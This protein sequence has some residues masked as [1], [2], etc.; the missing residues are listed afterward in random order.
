LPLITDIA[1]HR[2]IEP[3][4][5]ALAP[6]Q[7]RLA[8][9]ELAPLQ[10]YTDMGYCNAATIVDS[11]ERGIDLRGRVAH[12]GAKA[13]GFRLEDFE[14]D[15]AQRTAVCPQ[16]HPAQHFTPSTQP[17]VAFHVRFGKVCQSCPVKA[18]CTTEARGRSLEIR[19]HHAV[20]IARLRQQDTPDFRRE[21][22]ARARI[23]STLAEL[24][25]RHRL[26]RLRY[27][28]WQQG[29]LQVAFTAVAVNLKRLARHLAAHAATLTLS[30][31]A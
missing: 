30:R 1:L 15:V 6:I 13:P 10:Q 22:R 2:A 14:V 12:S 23:E 5:L 31:A 18:H 29:N 26:R 7:D 17:D 16:G 11:A 28:G 24:T 8:A 4:N 9:R 21:M 25:G 3:D 19:P 27:R 20:R